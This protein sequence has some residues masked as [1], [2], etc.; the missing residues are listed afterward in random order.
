MLSDH[1]LNALCGLLL[2]KKTLVKYDAQVVLIFNFFF[3]G[4]GGISCFFSPDPNCNEGCRLTMHSTSAKFSTWRLLLNEA[5]ETLYKINE[6][7]N[8][9]TKI[10]WIFK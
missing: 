1:N 5:A 7:Q 2:K 4:G 3:L 6:N 10:Y 8:C 9:S